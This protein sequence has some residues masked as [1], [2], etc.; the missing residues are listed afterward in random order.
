[1]RLLLSIVIII[2]STFLLIVYP[3]L[4]ILGFILGAAVYILGRK[5]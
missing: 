1:M 5:K 4:G 2:V 3:P